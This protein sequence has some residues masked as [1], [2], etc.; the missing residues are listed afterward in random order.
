MTRPPSP[1]R[2]T[3]SDATLARNLRLLRNQG[4][5]QRY[6]NELA[7]ANVRLTDVAAAIGRVQLGKLEDWTEQRRANAAA[8][9]AGL[10]GVVP[11]P[12]A[13]AATAMRR[14]SRVR[15]WRMR[16]RR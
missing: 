15:R 11:P 9:S 6:A 10:K 4:M 2:I 13:H 12:E 16:R 5:E 7:G 3:T 8:L 14:A 1:R